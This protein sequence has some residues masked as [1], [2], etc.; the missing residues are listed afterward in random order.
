MIKKETGSILGKTKVF[1]E[2]RSN[3]VRSRDFREAME[4]LQRLE[5][6]NQGRDLVVREVKTNEPVQV[7][8]ASDWHLGSISSDLEA[9]YETRDYILTHD[10]V[11]VIF[12][13]DEL[14]GL[15]HKYLSTNTA[16]T[17]IDFQQQVEILKMDFFDP[18]A[19]N[20]RV[21]AM[22]SEYWG[23]PGWAADATTI[24]TWRLMV[25]DLD[26]PIIKNGGDVEMVFPNK[27]RHRIKV[28]HNPPGSSKHD[29][30]VGLR[31]VMQGMTESARPKGAVSGHIHRMAV[32]KEIYAGAK[33][34]IYLISAGTYKGANSEKPRD[35]FG[36]RLGASLA[37]P[38]G[39]GVIVR[40]S[41][42]RRPEMTYPF[43]SLEHGEMAMD[44]MRLFDKVEAKGLKNELLAEIRKKVE[45]APEV[46]YGKATSRLG[47]IHTEE[48][49]MSKVVMGGETIV[50]PYSRMEMK[51]PYDT[52]SYEVKTRLPIALHLIQNA[53][54]GASSEG[55]KDLS[56]YVKKVS[57]NPHSL[58]VF[59]RNMLDKESGKSQ[60]R[61][62]ILANY[63][64]F[65]KGVEGQTL[66]VM[67]DESLRDPS[68]KKT[69]KIGTE[70]YVDTYGV[71]KTRNIY[72]PPIAPA[73]YLANIAE[74]P[75][76][77]HLSMIKLAIGPSGITLKEK[78]L[79]IGAFADKLEGYGSQSKPEW[80]LQRLYDLQIH[81]KPGYV[82]GGHMPSSGTMTIFDGANSE[83]NYPHLIAPGWWSSSVD[84]TGKGNVKP[85]SEPGQ[86]IIFMPGRTR[87]DYKSF[88]TVN[89]RETQ[90]MHDALMLLEG[91]KILERSK[92]GLRKKVLG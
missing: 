10:N 24:N 64:S 39:Q 59:L 11:L 6:D 41:S 66:A 4:R 46:I 70:D 92:P 87:S 17:P 1:P 35:S 22:V 53:R 2:V 56:L 54:I 76:I 80:G 68:W 40:P 78:P 47:G 27:Y 50:N 28:W 19:M 13:G 71:K 51:A 7:L 45:E 16:K 82:A 58:I 89:A 38:Q 44:A 5:I 42:G 86:A 23:H 52:L 91:L 20:G 29:E 30:V 63:V 32:A 49:P 65:V 31:E 72:S 57:E 14:E 33:N 12:A 55:I 9:M 69:I 75:L 21:L 36:T 74:V 43:A 79:Y 61:E 34:Q 88:P 83:T 73:S 77:H 3:D 90:D 62:D 48:R 26:I 37:H 25:G 85:G 18:L 15:T 81:E 8:V 60:D 84:T 67:M